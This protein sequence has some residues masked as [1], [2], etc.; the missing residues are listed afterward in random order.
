MIEPGS[1]PL[2]LADQYAQ[3]LREIHRSGEFGAT[4][5]DHNGEVRSFAHW[6]PAALP[7]QE[8]LELGFKGHAEN[9]AIRLRLA[10]RFDGLARVSP[11]DRYLERY[12]ERLEEARP[13]GQVGYNLK[14]GKYV[15]MWDEKA[16]LSRFCPDDARDESGRM[17]RRY[18]PHLVAKQKAGYR[19][20][21]GV[22]T[23][24]NPAPGQ[25]RQGM[26]DIFKRLQRRVLKAKFPDG[27]PRFPEI[28]GVL[29]VLEAPLGG[30][31]DWNVH[32]NVI[33]VVDEYLSY[34][35]LRKAWFYDLH[36]DDPLPEGEAAIRGALS[37]LIKY[38]VAATVAKSARKAARADDRPPAPPM[39]E[40]RDDEL[41]EWVRGMRGFRRSRSYG[42]LYGLP[43]VEPDAD[44]LGPILWLCTFNTRGGGRGFDLR[45][46]LLRSIPE[47]KS[48]GRSPIEQW[49]AMKK[50]LDPDALAAAGTLGDQ[51]PPHVLAEVDL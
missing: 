29:A 32:L 48:I 26:T 20:Q 46:P 6:A 27:S 25:L 31:R 45:I 50:S 47:D 19:L 51:I 13:S 10:K 39:L 1:L 23:I 44:L 3:R 35:K 30:Y 37:E 9:E 7:S 17:V 22:L 11:E 36:I 28:K 38:A 12:A 5:T 33:F 14:T 43:E 8:Q 2:D 16:G 21:S 41:L 24:P 4:F 18:M 15:K 34:G 42:C 49:L 40:W